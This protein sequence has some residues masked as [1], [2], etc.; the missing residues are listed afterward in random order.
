MRKNGDSFGW[1]KDFYH[2]LLKQTDSMSYKNN[3]QF[4][5]VSSEYRYSNSMNTRGS[6]Q[7]KFIMKLNCLEMT[8]RVK[9]ILAMEMLDIHLVSVMIEEL[10]AVIENIIG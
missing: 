9:D 4:K 2:E 5:M 1:L 10:Y 7:F 8:R 3:Y 6:A